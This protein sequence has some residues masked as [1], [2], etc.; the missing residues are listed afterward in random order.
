M[1]GSYLES[2][3]SSSGG[4]S[5]SRVESLDLGVLGGVVDTLDD[6]EV[7]G[8]D[9]SEVVL[10]DAGEDGVGFRLGGSGCWAGD[11]EVVVGLS[12]KDVASRSGG[13]GGGTS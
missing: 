8:G 10:V 4:G 9:R 12:G 5:D 6:L 13:G 2:I 11:L 7:R 3:G 1:G